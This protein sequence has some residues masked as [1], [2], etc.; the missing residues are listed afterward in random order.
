MSTSRLILMRFAVPGVSL[1]HNECMWHVAAMSI[2]GLCWCDDPCMQA[3]AIRQ[4]RLQS[5]QALLQHQAEE[6]KRRQEHIAFVKHAGSSGLTGNGISSTGSEEP[7]VRLI[8]TSNV[9][10]PGYEPATI[11]EATQVGPAPVSMAALVAQ[12]ACQHMTCCTD[13]MLGISSMCYG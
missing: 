13:A 5:E 4:L 9:V 8:N 2:E 11:A 3:L 12:L 6:L 10:A 1:W 7:V